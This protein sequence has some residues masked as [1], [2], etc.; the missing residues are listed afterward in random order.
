MVLAR[1]EEEGRTFLN[2]CLV[3]GDV[4]SEKRARKVKRRALLLSILLQLIV[5]AA[6]ILFPLLGRSERISLAGVTPLPPYAPIGSS[7]RTAG[8]S[9]PKPGRQRVCI[10]CFSPSSLP[11]L[12]PK[13]ETVA[14]TLDDPVGD[15]VPGSP[16][17][18]GV[19]GGSN[20][21]GS[22]RLPDPPSS[23][24]G[25]KKEDKRIVV[26]HIEPALLLYRVEPIYPPL[27]KQI[28]KSGRVE[29]HA[30]IAMDGSIQSLEVVSGDPLF[31]KSALDAVGAWR[32]RATILNGHAVEVDTHIT[33]IYTLN[34]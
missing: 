20:P 23:D 34:N 2:S 30:L 12:P 22:R 21:F 16:E 3:E 15:Y 33:V 4:E 9:H 19:P 6:L 7:H 24:V 11:K 26:G 5:L 13:G 31:Y 1:P 14:R 8:D 28:H 10:V 32:Y 17:G 27:A 29:L 25:P 18:P